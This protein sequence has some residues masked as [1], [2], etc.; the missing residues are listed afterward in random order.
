V[1]RSERGLREGPRALA[2]EHGHDERGC[3]AAVRPRQRC[4]GGAFEA[5]LRVLAWQTR[6][7]AALAKVLERMQPRRRLRQEQGQQ[8]QDDDRGLAAS[9]QGVGLDGSEDYTRSR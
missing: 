8:R 3:G 5:K 4:K 2:G 6:P 9:N 7:V 1:L